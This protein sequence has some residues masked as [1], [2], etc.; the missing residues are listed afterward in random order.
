MGTMP[1]P[2]IS[3][4]LSNF[5]KTNFNLRFVLLDSLALI[6]ASHF[7]ARKKKEKKRTVW[8]CSKNSR[9]LTLSSDRKIFSY[10]CVLRNKKIASNSDRTKVLRSTFHSNFLIYFIFLK[11]NHGFFSRSFRICL[12]SFAVCFSGK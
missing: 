12:L 2:N 9:T 7:S 8:L 10:V 5:L 1:F 6:L 4:I 11:F 3:L